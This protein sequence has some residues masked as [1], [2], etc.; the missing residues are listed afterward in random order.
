[1][2]LD[3]DWIT[4][5]GL[6]GG[7]RKIFS[8]ALR[9]LPPSIGPSSGYIYTHGEVGGHVSWGVGIGTSMIRIR[10]VILIISF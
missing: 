10:R 6:C 7:L 1:M 3:L 8:G 2:G 4:N 5:R 9:L